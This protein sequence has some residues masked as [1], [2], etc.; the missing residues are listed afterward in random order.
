MRCG[1]DS[2][3]HLDTGHALIAAQLSVHAYGGPVMAFAICT[4][5]HELEVK[6]DFLIRKIT[7]KIVHFRFI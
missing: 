1:H 5:L 6:I 4:G 2:L 3:L 7:L